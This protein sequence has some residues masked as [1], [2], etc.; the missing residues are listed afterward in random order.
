MVLIKKSVSDIENEYKR[1]FIRYL[2]ECNLL[3][4]WYQYV[5]SPQY[6]RFAE[7]YISSHKERSSL[8]YDRNYCLEIMDMCNFYHFIHM[9][10]GIKG[11]YEPYDDLI[12]FMAIFW[13]E[14]YDKWAKEV[15][16]KKSAKKYVEVFL[17]YQ[18]Y[19]NKDRRARV[20]RWVKLKQTL[21]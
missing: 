5:N 16:E 11:N 13:E 9:V 14:E 8:W 6:R 15:D 12:L 2:K 18:H 1:V 19:G 3:Y 20:E 7:I 10:K 17:S 21:G 4:L